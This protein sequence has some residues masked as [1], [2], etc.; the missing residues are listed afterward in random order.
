MERESFGLWAIGMFEPFC[1]PNGGLKD[2]DEAPARHP[3]N[4][5]Q[6][7]HPRETMQFESMPT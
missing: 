7:W 4:S 5:K 6:L 3:L 1:R 2:A